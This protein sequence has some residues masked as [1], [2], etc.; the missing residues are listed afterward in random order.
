V[1]PEVSAGGM[2]R[3]SL[4]KVISNQSGELLSGT[5]NTDLL[6]TFQ[7]ERL[8]CACA[9]PSGD[10]FGPLLE[11]L[12]LLEL[13]ELLNLLALTDEHSPCSAARNYDLS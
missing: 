2:P 9:S 11:L 4:P 13:L 3:R 1:G 5:L 8:P 6:I 7:I 12:Q 10:A